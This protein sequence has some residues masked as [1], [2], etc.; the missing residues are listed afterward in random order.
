MTDYPTPSDYQEAVQVPA[1]AFRES[2]LQ[3]ATPQTNVLGLPQPIT[4]AFAAVFPMTV[5]T[6]QQVAVKCF[7]ND[8]P[9]QQDRYAAVADHL[10]TV[11]LDALVGFDYQPEGIRVDGTAY[12]ILKMEWWRARC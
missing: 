9:Q 3:D 10:A 2:A 1:A 4:G 11:D 8:V 5:E 12:P 7:L 6:G